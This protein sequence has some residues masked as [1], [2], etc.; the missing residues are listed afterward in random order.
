MF[1]V[2]TSEGE[3]SHYRVY[4]DGTSTVVKGGELS[5]GYR[6]VVRKQLGLL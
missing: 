1:A 5:P 4:V 3:G 2:R 6:R